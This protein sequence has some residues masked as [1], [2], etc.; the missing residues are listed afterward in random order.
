[1]I[2]FLKYLKISLHEKLIE[3]NY[4][5]ETKWADKED[6]SQRIT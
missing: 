5:Q 4:P 2:F 1:M 6:G 3:F